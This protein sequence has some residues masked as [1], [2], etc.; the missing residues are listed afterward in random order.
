MFAQ[1]ALASLLATVPLARA[2]PNVT[3]KVLPSDDC[4]SYPGYDAAS[5]TAGPWTVQLVDSDNAAIEGFSDTSAYSVSFNPSTDRKP[6]LR[7]GSITFPTR[8]DIA[9]NPLK[10][11]EGILK[12]YL[13]TDLTDAG[14]PTSYQWVPLVLSPYPYDAAL[15]WKIDGEAPQIFEHYIDGEKQDGVFLGSYN[16]TTSWG[17]KYNSANVG[18]TRDYFYARLLGPNSADPV[19]KQPLAANETTAFI[20]ISA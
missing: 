6:S 2:T 20:K 4:S 10:C 16:G 5:N 13:P 18:S 7:W 15:M 14:A 17:L 8:N 12:G 1:L 11:E 3:A 9:K 19:T